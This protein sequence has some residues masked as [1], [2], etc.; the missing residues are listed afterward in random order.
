MIPF[1]RIVLAVVSCT[2]DP[3]TPRPTPEQAIAVI[4]PH[5]GPIVVLPTWDWRGPQSYVLPSSPTSGPFGELSAPEPAR[6]LDGTLWTEPPWLLRTYVG[7]SYGV[8]NPRH[9][10]SGRR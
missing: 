4:R 3:S 8:N 5:V 6:R 7:R 1:C 10:R 9:A 2:L